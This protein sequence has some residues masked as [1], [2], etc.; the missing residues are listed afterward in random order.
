VNGGKRIEATLVDRIQDRHGRTVYRHDTRECDA[1]TKVAFRN[2]SMPAVPDAREQ[3]LDPDNAFQIVS[4]LQGAAQRSPSVQPLGRR[5]A[6]KTG[7][8]NESVDAWFVGFSSDLAVAVWV[9]FDRPRSLGKKETGSIAASPIFAQFM[10]AAADVIPPRDFVPPK[11][12]VAVQTAAGTEYYK[13]GTEPAVR[14][15][16]DIDTAEGPGAVPRAWTDDQEIIESDMPAQ[17]EQ[18]PPRSFSYQPPQYA[19]PRRD[20]Y[21]DL[22][23][24]GLSA[25][26]H[27]DAPLPAPR[28][29]PGVIYR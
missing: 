26:P 4:I 14:P 3:V 21:R 12:L 8:T 24:P 13:P 27:V 28:S 15:S 1:C 5:F 22:P 7:S 20:H 2:Q 23:P 16:S 18:W 19:E 17:P 9:G 10:R 25:P 11:D 6:G 29:M